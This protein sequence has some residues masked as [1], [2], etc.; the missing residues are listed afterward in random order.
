MF[1]EERGH[2][3]MLLSRLCLPDACLLTKLSEKVFVPACTLEYGRRCILARKPLE[4][5]AAQHVYLQ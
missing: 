5:S 4:C 2:Q 1:E 3:L